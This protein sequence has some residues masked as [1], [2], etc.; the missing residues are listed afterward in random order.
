MGFVSGFISR[1]ASI[2][3]AVMEGVGKIGEKIGGAISGFA[4]KV[5]EVIENI[6]NLDF[7]KI[8]SN[9]GNIIQGIA[10]V[11]GIK[12]EENPEILGAKVEQGDKKME[13][14]DNDVERYIQYLREEVKLDKEK[15]NRMTEEEKL[16]CKVVGIS[17]ETK[18]IEAKIGDVE[19]SPECLAALAKIDSE[20]I[21]IDAKEL[22]KII[23]ILKSEGITNLNDVVE[24]LEGK[25]ESDRI[26]TGDALEKALGEGA[27][28]KIYELQDAVRKYEEN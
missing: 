16:G 17:L 3:S 11:L 25:G 19:I 1:I 13:D 21:H 20:G 18:A 23:N 15:L 5:V 27:Q 28:D 4:G 24:F 9:I 12:V 14:F 10:Q 7:G 6:P 8:I 2:G 22:V 26:K